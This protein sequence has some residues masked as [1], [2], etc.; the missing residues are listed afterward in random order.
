MSGKFEQLLGLLSLASD[1]V[2]SV[3]EQA[4]DLHRRIQRPLGVTPVSNVIEG[5]TQTVHRSVRGIAGLTGFAAQT[6]ASVFA[7]SR[8]DPE[9][10]NRDFLNARS[11][12]NG[13][14]G[15][16]LARRKNPLALSMQIVSKQPSAPDT[17][18]STQ[19]SRPK[20]AKTKA[21][22]AL[23]VHGLCLNETHWGDAHSARLKALG[24][25]PLFLRYNSG[26][27]IETNGRELA[28]LLSARTPRNAEWAI[29]AHSMGGLVV[30]VALRELDLQKHPV[31]RPFS[32]V[33]YLGTPHTGAPLEHAGSWVH[34]IW[35][36]LPFAGALAPV[37]GLRSQGILDLGQGLPNQRTA[38]KG[39]REYVIAASLRK[40]GKRRLGT[41]AD[42]SLG[43]G[44][45]PVNS[46]LGVDSFAAM[47][48]DQQTILYGI[49][50]MDL[51]H[52]PEVSQQLERWLVP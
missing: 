7:Q 26:V 27:S 12:L 22:Y 3:S 11:V 19:Q 45:V 35:K 29:V 40:A 8:K 23:F 25:T 15:D 9:S 28:A 42:Q 37:A 5:V 36:T 30:R 49:G 52:A 41:L 50:H 46:A 31:L 4:Q 51:L 47:P 6:L 43:D 16:H 18:Q 10:N 32:K 20:S 21:R 1:A 44:L 17:Q 33:I 39:P 48:A 24:Y 13:V 38:R 14:C 2:V 34:S